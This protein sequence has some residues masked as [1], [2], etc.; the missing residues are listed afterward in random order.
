MIRYSWMWKEGASAALSKG[1]AEAGPGPGEEDDSAADPAAG[2]Q[3]AT[4]IGAR[5]LRVCESS[6][7][8]MD[9]FKIRGLFLMG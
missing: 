7:A 4:W 8:G 1:W 3:I 9:V 2:I 6:V 5:I